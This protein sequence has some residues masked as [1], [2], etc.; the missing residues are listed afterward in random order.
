MKI[1]GLE[2]SRFG[3]WRRLKLDPLSSE[4]NVLYGQ[5]ETGKTTLLEF[6]RA[7]LY[8]PTPEHRKK[9]LSPELNGRWGGTLHLATDS[10]KFRLSRQW[11]ARDAEHVNTESTLWDELGTDHDARRFQEFLHGIDRQT[12]RHVF[13]VSLR[14]LQHFN[15]LDE[16]SAAR[17]LYEMTAG[18]D[19]VSLPDVLR[20][21]DEASNGIWDKPEN[22]SSVTSLLKR[23]RALLAEIKEG[24]ADVKRFAQ[25]SHQRRQREQEITRREQQQTAWKTDARRLE[26]A[27]SLRDKWVER[28]KLLRHKKEAS[29]PFPAEG[30]ARLEQI[31]ERLDKRKQELARW[32]GRRARLRER[33]AGLDINRALWSQSAKIAVLGEQQTWMANL[34]QQLDTAHDS[35]HAS[36]S[37]LESQHVQL[38]IAA[39]QAEGSLPYLEEDAVASVREFAKT[40][41]R[42]ERRLDRLKQEA[43]QARREAARLEEDSGAALR[44]LGASKLTIALQE[45]GQ[46]S[47]RLRQRV[48]LDERLEDLS[49]RE[50]ELAERRRELL[51]R[52]LLPPWILLLLG[53]GFVLG[54]TLILVQLF[55]RSFAAEW[56]WTLALIGGTGV[57][58]AVVLQKVLERIARVRSDN[59]LR[60][61]ETLALEKQHTNEEREALDAEFPLSRPPRELLELAEERLEKLEALL[62]QD[63]RRAEAKKRAK[64]LAAR[65]SDAEL[66]LLQAEEQWR[67]VL[68]VSGLPAT[69]K[70]QQV[71]QLSSRQG[72]WNELR[73][74]MGLR[75]EELEQRERELHALENSILQLIADSGLEPESESADAQLRQLQR[76]LGKQQ[77]VFQERDVLEQRLQEV[78]RR[79]RRSAEALATWKKKKRA[80]LAETGVEDE[81]QFRQAARRHEEARNRRRRLEKLEAEIQQA[82]SKPFSEAELEK[83]LAANHRDSLEHDW[84]D[85]SGKLE[86]VSEHL[87]KL[88]EERGKD[89]QLAKTKARSL[90]IAEKKLELG[91]VE[92]NLRETIR[93]WRAHALANHTLRQVCQK[94]EKERQPETLREASLHFQKMTGGRYRRVW[95]RVGER[96]LRVDDAHGKL[97]ECEELSQGTREQ[98][99]LCLRLALVT[100]LRRRGVTLPMILDDVLVNFDNERV[101]SAAEVLRHFTQSGHQV[102]VFTCHRHIQE[103]FAATE[104]QIVDLAHPDTATRHGPPQPSP[105]PSP[106]PAKKP[107]TVPRPI[108][109]VEPGY[110]EEPKE[111]PQRPTTPKKPSKKRKKMKP[112]RTPPSEPASTVASEAPATK[113]VEAKQA[114][115][116]VADLPR[117]MPVPHVR[118]WVGDAEFTQP[119]APL[120]AEADEIDLLLGQDRLATPQGSPPPSSLP[121]AHQPNDQDQ[122]ADIPPSREPRSEN[123]QSWHAE[124]PDQEIRSSD[125][126]G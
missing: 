81:F 109:T 3:V 5:N 99:F 36:A 20:E 100:T 61:L 30:F 108:E 31:N 93:Q 42:A 45:A 88:Y 21:L 103:I 74:R 37:E 28:E 18:L 27:I 34:R 32:R 111:L 76:E 64:A 22:L 89:E 78:S 80:L 104:A 56:G 120:A 91:I 124:W 122:S 14:E 68:E 92:T 118:A 87:K 102:F 117:A 71:R 72:H 4:L 85:V 105:E 17:L 1:V 51:E 7:M 39:D 16:A 53:A 49:I 101:R 9:Y 77:K 55:L 59:Y 40:C 79:G 98:L 23:R 48:Q 121:N 2:I 10:G 41:Y 69:L 13:A 112:D 125:D 63:T 119:E 8:L 70:P 62:P 67:D 66:E 90:P 46:D 65:I 26:L 15:T 50:E 6:L 84:E 97:W 44:E 43:E 126:N 113:P 96:S 75:Q 110:E 12:F 35:L 29:T 83:L 82:A 94:L 73:R 25:L 114:T 106:Q 116:P 38:G 107:A 54:L 47:R 123:G 95:T 57:A 24:V 60:Q 33:L 11:S 115:S 52:Q 58:V 86:K 19:R